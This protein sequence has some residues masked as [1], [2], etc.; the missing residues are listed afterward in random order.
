VVFDEPSSGVDRRHL[1]SISDQIR[2]VATDGAVV[3]LI[4]HDDDL[5]ALAADRQLTLAP[6]QC[7]RRPQKAT[8]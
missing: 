2:Q 3:L 8:A 7:G 5:T 4:S 6:P 1:Q